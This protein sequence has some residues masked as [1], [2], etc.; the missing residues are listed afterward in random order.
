MPRIAEAYG[1]EMEPNLASLGCF[2]Q[3]K[4][5]RHP[6]MDRRAGRDDPI[7]L[8]ENVLHRRSGAYR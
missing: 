2:D 8:N 5:R 3:L 4:R 6:F 7:G 1:W